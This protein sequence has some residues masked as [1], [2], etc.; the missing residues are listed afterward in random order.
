MVKDAS[1][2]G[3]NAGDGAAADDGDVPDLEKGT[4]HKT[5]VSVDSGG[6]HGDNTSVTVVV[7]SGDSLTTTAQP[8]P[9]LSATDTSKQELP[10]PVSPKKPYL[11]RT[12]SSPEQCR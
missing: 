9:E 8:E 1:T 11:S 3:D 4:D 12:T 5:A 7:S 10:T 6:D 2:S